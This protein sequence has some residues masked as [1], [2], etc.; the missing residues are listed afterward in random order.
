MSQQQE[1]DE[2]GDGSAVREAADDR[3]WEEIEPKPFETQKVSYVICL[4]TM[5]QDREFTE[6]EKKFA[7]RTAKEYALQWEEVERINLQNDIA[8]RME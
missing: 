6:E 2:E 5:G 3:K 8:L 4:N 1:Q 7:L